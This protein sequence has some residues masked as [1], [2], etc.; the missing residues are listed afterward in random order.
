[1]LYRVDSF[2]L[3]HCTALWSSFVL[4]IEEQYTSER[5]MQC[6]ESQ[7]SNGIAIK[8]LDWNWHWGRMFVLAMIDGSHGDLGR[9]CACLLL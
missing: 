2:D 8:Q 3:N 6:I 9:P 4:C 7:W 5:F 1:M